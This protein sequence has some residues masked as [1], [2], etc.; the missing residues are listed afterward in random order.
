M[1]NTQEISSSS[2]N[3]FKTEEAIKL[4]NSNTEYLSKVEYNF[5]LNCINDG[6][7]KAFRDNLWHFFREAKLNKIDKEEASSEHNDF[8]KYKT[9]TFKIKKLTHDIDRIQ[10]NLSE[11]MSRL[12]ESEEVNSVLS[13]QN[14]AL[15]KL[16]TEKDTLL[17]ESLKKIKNLE[18]INADLQSKVQQ[19]RIDEKIP[20]YVNNVKSELGSDDTH[21]IKMSIIWAIAGVCFGIAAVSMSL[22]TLFLKIDFSDIKT[23][24][25]FYIFSRG[26]IG[27]AILSWLSFIC[28]GN[29]KK[30]THESIRRKDRR[31]ALMFGQV[32][33]QIYGATASKEDAILVFKDW[34]MSGD[35]AFSGQTEQP[36]N[37]LSMLA[38]VKE[39]L[40]TPSEMKVQN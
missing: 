2:L 7:F 27:I 6:D 1:E 31:H 23:S 40:K 29:S 28:L 32:Y 5:L 38:N 26:I 19:E 11:Y 18:G 33:L 10:Q 15:E 8:K 37:A 9:D 30:Y 24:E 14:K 3:D 25:L 16:S 22:Y 13:I 20:N 34:N 4:L 35:S 36:P 17:N 21:F 39:K 12:S